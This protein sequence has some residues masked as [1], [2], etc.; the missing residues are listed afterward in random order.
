MMPKPEKQEVV[1]LT[2]RQTAKL[3]ILSERA[4]RMME[5][6]GELPAIHVG[7]RC[8]INKD[9]FLRQLNSVTAENPM[10]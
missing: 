7:N 8:Y 1:F 9:A 3:G 5:K 2:I 4:L 6:R 10:T